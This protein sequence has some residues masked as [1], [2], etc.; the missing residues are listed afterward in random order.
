MVGE[1]WPRIESGA[2]ALPVDSRFDLADVARALDRA[3]TGRPR[4]KV[5]LR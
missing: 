4:G 1:L 3:T 2:L 5:L